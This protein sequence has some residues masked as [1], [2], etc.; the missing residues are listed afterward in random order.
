MWQHLRKLA[1]NNALQRSR[2][3]FH[4]AKNYCGASV[5]CSHYA[6][7]LGMLQRKVK[8]NICR[9]TFCIFFCA[10]GG[11]NNIK[12]IVKQQQKHKSTGKL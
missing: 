4:A 3:Q 9:N 7:A 1:C 2:K 5:A 11:Y 12:I 10:K 6:D 8:E